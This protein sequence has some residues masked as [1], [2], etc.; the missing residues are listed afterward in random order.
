MFMFRARHVIRENP[1]ARALLGVVMILASVVIWVIVGAGHGRL[2]AV[3]AL[4]L[5]GGVASGSRGLHTKRTAESERQKIE[6]DSPA[7]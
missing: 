5:V 6:S 7:P 2:A 1:W 4:L 3:G